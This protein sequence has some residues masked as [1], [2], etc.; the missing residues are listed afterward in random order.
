M[1][2]HKIVEAWLGE[3]DYDGL[4]HDDLE[5]GCRLGD[6]MP[7][8]EPSTHCMAGYEVETECSEHDFHISPEKEG[9]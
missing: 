6:L 9:E 1:K 3:N 5:C 8:G 7:C 2:M 4:Y